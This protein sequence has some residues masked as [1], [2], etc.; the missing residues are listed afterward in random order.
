MTDEE[1]NNIHEGLNLVIGRTTDL[2]RHS[3]WGKAWDDVFIDLIIE[4]LMQETGQTREAIV[5]M[6][7][8][9]HRAKYQQRLEAIENISP[10]R[11]AQLDTRGPDDIAL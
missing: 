6:L 4:R 10:A 9:R 11:A 2:M 7:N 8:D 5:A 3:I 1:K